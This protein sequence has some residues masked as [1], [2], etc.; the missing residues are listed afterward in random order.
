[1][2]FLITLIIACTPA[3]A[4]D[5]GLNLSAPNGYMSPYQQEM[6][7]QGYFHEKHWRSVV[8]VRSVTNNIVT[9]DFWETTWNNGNIGWPLELWTDGRW[10]NPL[11]GETGTI[12]R[13]SHSGERPT[14]HLDK[15][16]GVIYA[17][18]L[19]VYKDVPAKT[20]W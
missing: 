18:H 13:F 19:F 2:R 3:F 15:N 4:I 14:F 12:M 7:P 1:M 10:E 5:A 20:Q 9:A 8:T 17:G 16:P 11:T 6:I